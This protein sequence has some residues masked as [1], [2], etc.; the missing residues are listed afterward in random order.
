MPQASGGGLYRGH[1]HAFFSS[2]RGVALQ[3][4][5][6][7]LQFN[8]LFSGSNCTVQNV[9]NSPNVWSFGHP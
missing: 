4:I 7:G 3:K 1:Q 9:Q 8:T 6:L 2:L 5:T